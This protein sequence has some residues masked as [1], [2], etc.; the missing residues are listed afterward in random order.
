MHQQSVAEHVPHDDQ[1]GLLVVHAHPVHPQ[2]LRQQRAAVTLHDVLQ[3]QEV[4]KSARSCSTFIHNSSERQLKTSPNPQ[5]CL[6]IMKDAVRCQRWNPD[7]RLVIYGSSKQ[8]SAGGAFSVSFQSDSVNPVSADTRT[9]SAPTPEPREPRHQNHVSPASH[10]VILRQD[11]VHVCNVLARD[12]LD[13]QCPVIG[14]EEETLS[15]V[16]CAPHRGAP[17]QCDLQN[18]KAYCS[19]RRSSWS[20]PSV[21]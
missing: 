20:L 10:L 9:M 11:V 3:T 18:P 17:G 4:I 1:V 21:S 16:I 2:E 13:D 7:N 19:I 14:V 12:L 15:L 8:F 6:A 5:N